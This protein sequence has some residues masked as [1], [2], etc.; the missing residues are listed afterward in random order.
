MKKISKKC[1]KMWAG[2]KRDLGQKDSSLGYRRVFPPS[3]AVGKPMER[4]LCD[5]ISNN[6]A[7][8]VIII[9][10]DD[11]KVFQS[12]E[13]FVGSINCGTAKIGRKPSLESGFWD[14]L[15]VPSMGPFRNVTREGIARAPAGCSTA[16]LAGDKLGGGFAAV[17]FAPLVPRPC[18]AAPAAV[19]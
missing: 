16:A 15:G 13:R 17:D 8:S 4:N 7:E 5:R 12:T 18:L 2:G 9:D 11:Y 3:I 6:E 10:S 1:S 19:P 14:G